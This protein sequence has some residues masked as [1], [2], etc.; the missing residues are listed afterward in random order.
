MMLDIKFKNIWL[1]KS[2]IKA[3]T[4]TNEIVKIAEPTPK[5]KAAEQ[6]KTARQITGNTIEIKFPFD[7]GT[8]AAIKTRIKS[9]RWN[10]DKKIWTA[11]LTVSNIQA[12]VDLGFEI[13]DRLK[14]IL[15]NANKTA[16]GS[17]PT[18]KLKLN[19]KIGKTLFPYQ[20]AGIEFA[21]QCNGN[22]LIA[23]EMGLGKT[24]QA[25][26]WLELHPEIRPAVIVVPASLKLNWQKE[27]DM[28]M[29]KKKKSVICSG[30][31]P[32]KADKKALTK[33]D[34]IIINY[35]ILSN[36]WLDE[37]KRIKIQAMIIDEV[38][39]IK[40][41]AAKRTKAVMKL[42]RM[43]N[44]TLALS[45]TPIT[46]RPI[47]LFT[48]IK[49]LAP[50][51]FGSK[52]EFAQEFCNARHNG[53]GWDFS[54][55]KNTEKLHKILTESIM[56][57]RLKADV[58]KDLPAKMRSVVPMEITNRSVYIK[59]ESDF[60]SYL[61]KIDPEKAKSAERAE[62]LVQIEGLKQLTI[63]GKIKACKLWI[64]EHLETNGKLVVFCTHKSTINHLMAAFKDV[65]V[66]L[67][68][69]TSQTDRQV[70]VDKFQ[71]D[72]SVRLFVG[73]IKAAGV[74]ITLTAASSVAFLEFPWTPAELDQGEDRIHRIGQE[75]DSVNIYYLIADQTI[76]TEIAELLDKKRKVIQSVLDGKEVEDENLLTELINKYK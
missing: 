48:T 39:M 40:S 74:G 11:S 24:I 2:A 29:S 45:G 30:R 68:G 4:D 16:A 73:N 58:L 12:L 38:H 62:T 64:K 36:E 75:A 52:F 9:R 15:E 50:Q 51:L 23:D 57:R 53:F 46:N 31:K 34:L 27:I 5:E 61:K 20:K 66:K 54:G 44:H 10:P 41:P 32:T 7:F 26:G 14:A 59:A 28:W 17:A 43:V 56:I 37:F 13:G 72:D 65:A 3:V 60:I 71:T 76:E 6:T 47:E 1:P 22:V 25:L 35:D 8:L 63:A 55:A 70:V 33:T 67:D 19:G 42:K 49:M 69:S 18:Q 21:E